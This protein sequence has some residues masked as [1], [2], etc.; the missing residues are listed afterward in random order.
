LRTESIEALGRGRRG[1]IERLLRFSGSVRRCLA[2]P[3]LERGEYGQRRRSA[4]AKANAPGRERARPVVAHVSG[5]TDVE[6]C[7]RR[8]IWRR[9][10]HAQIVRFG[11][12]LVAIALSQLAEAQPRIPSAGPTSIDNRLE[13]RVCIVLVVQLQQRL[14]AIELCPAPIGARRVD[15]VEQ[16]D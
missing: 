6:Q 13:A 9:L 5:E 4:A 8:A 16:R 12:Y 2:S 11:G 15:L 3:V 10:G 14:H 1:P 7:L